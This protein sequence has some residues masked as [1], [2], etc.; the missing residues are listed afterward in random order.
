MPQSQLLGQLMDQMTYLNERDD[1]HS[2]YSRQFASWRAMVCLSCAIQN[3]DL[4]SST[5]S[6][7]YEAYQGRSRSSWD[8]RPAKFCEARHSELKCSDTTRYMIQVP[9][10]W[11]ICPDTRLSVYFANIEY[12][13]GFFGNVECHRPVNVGICLTAIGLRHL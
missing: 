9:W 3:L 2:S 11:A 5:L 13:I 1:Q 6:F 8:F 7:S 12:F 4:T 10:W